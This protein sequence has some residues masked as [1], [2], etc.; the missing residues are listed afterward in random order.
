M[1]P[2]VPGGLW[3]STATSGSCYKRESQTP[4]MVV[5]TKLRKMSWPGWRSNPWPSEKCSDALTCFFKKK[6]DKQNKLINQEEKNHQSS[7]VIC[8][9]LAFCS[10]FSHCFLQGQAYVAEHV[11]SDFDV[12]PKEAEVMCKRQEKVRRLVVVQ[13]CIICTA[14]YSRDG[15]IHDD[16]RERGS[17]YHMSPHGGHRMR[18]ADWPVDK[19]DYVKHT[20]F[21]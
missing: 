15:C 5:R 6:I 18:S 10:L 11:H 16:H 4:A 3:G 17:F 21:Q 19:K 20:G 8:L 2:F 13:R 9:S 14:F 7:N 1:P 12:H